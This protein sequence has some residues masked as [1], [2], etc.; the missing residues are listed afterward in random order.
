MRA[1]GWEVRKKKL[2]VNL[3]R[4]KGGRTEGKARVLQKK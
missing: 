2:E 4:G 1:E 3:K